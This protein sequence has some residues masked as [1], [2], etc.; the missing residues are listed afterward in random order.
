MGKIKSK[1]IRRTAK[2][3]MEQGIEFSEDFEKNKRI[4]GQEMPSKRMRNQLAGFL[5]R[6]SKNKAKEKA[7]LKVD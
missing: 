1:Q 4:L 6:F 2:E 5:V 3:I 7:L